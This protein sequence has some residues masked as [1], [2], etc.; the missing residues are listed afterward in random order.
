VEKGLPL[1][2]KA[3]RRKETELEG[4]PTGHRKPG[5]VVLKNLGEP[6]ILYLLLFASG[7]VSQ[8]T[9]PEVISFSLRHACIRLFAY[10]IPSLGLIWYLIY[11]HPPRL[12]G[13]WITA[14]LTPRIHDLAG[15]GMALLGLGGIGFGIAQAGPLLQGLLAPYI[16]IPPGPRLETPQRLPAWLVILGSCLGTGYLEESYF[17]LYLLLRLEK[18]GIGIRKGVFLSC[19]LFSLCHRYEGPWGVLQAALAGIV[20]SLVLIRYRSFHG[21]ALAHGA[22]NGLVYLIAHVGP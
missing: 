8:G 4:V 5:L 3:N 17:R 10:T 21:I 19:L 13:S 2:L 14:I 20:L 16:T 6:L 15:L 12:E 9:Y 7:L 11:R 1:S 22:Y 18:A